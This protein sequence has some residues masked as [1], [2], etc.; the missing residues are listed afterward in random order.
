MYGKGQKWHAELLKESSIKTV[1][2]YISGDVAL[3]GAPSERT[4]KGKERAPRVE[5]AFDR[6]CIPEPGLQV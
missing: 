6:G 5:F 2:L 3:Y 1:R 4:M